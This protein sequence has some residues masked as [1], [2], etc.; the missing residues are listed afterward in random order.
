MKTAKQPPVD[1]SSSRRAQPLRQTR[2]N[3][4]RLSLAGSRQFGSRASLGGLEG[5]S[6]PEQTVEIFPAITHFADAI[7][8]LP[9]E[10]VR[11]FT[12]LKEV[13]AKIF[14]PEE[15][16]GNLIDAALNAPLAERR[17][18]VE[19]RNGLGPT[20]AHM[21]AQDSASGS[22]IKG[23]VG[24][25]AS[26]PEV[27]DNSLDATWDPANIPRR[28]LFQNCAYTM[29]N[30]LLSLDEKNHVIA[31]A[32][33]ALNKQLARIDDCFPSIEREI[34]E[35]ARL[36]SLKHWAYPENR[37][38]KASGGAR[39]D[40]TSVN[41]PSAAAQRLVDEAAARSD[42]RKQAVAAKKN[43]HK[44]HAESDFDD[45][46]DA[47]QK[48][49]K[50]H[51]NSK[52]RKAAD[53]SLGVGLGISNGTSNGNPPKRRKVEKAPPGGIGMERA[54]SGVFGA[55]GTA[56]KKAASPRETPPGDGPKKRVRA[57]NATN[58]HSRKRYDFFS[59]S[60]K[61]FC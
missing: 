47:R 7:A 54:L 29:S 56:T 36:G 44:T 51:G 16:L 40:L 32:A 38:H 2:N 21:S 41:T 1:M 43:N 4:P 22:V 18:L 19:T 17:Q 30:M 48:D 34:S 60:H 52:V 39:R 53:A 42:E 49:K 45:H 9:K 26:L 6:S 58:G 12:L 5:A 15:S 8:A 23:H 27:V 14:A 33:E 11:H 37:T 10:L 20:S 55:N 24:S 59:H 57:P 61:L 13:D 35:E 25:A 31:T 50:S 3:P 28:Q 46:H